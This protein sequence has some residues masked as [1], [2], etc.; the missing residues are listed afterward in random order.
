MANTLVIIAASPLVAAL[1]TWFFLREHV[2]LRTW[3]AAAAGFGGIAII[4]L[5]EMGHGSFAGNLLAA[6]SGCALGATFV[7]IRFA[8]AK[9]M[10]PAVGLTGLFVATMTAPVVGSWAVSA[11][12]LALIVLLGG[13][14][15]TLS[16]GLISLGPRYLPAP[17]V[18]LLMLLETVL[19][20][21]WVWLALGEEPA[22]AT[23]IGGTILIGALVIHS[24]LSLREDVTRGTMREIE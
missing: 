21:L 19:G 22:K 2:P 13:V 11:T 20:P 18:N 24:M 10:V 8:K 3:L 6:G 23:W 17:N 12:D 15:S 14:I 16:F 1:F 5:T 4:F 7:I 9:S